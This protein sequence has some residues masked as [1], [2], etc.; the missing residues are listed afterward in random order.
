MANFTSRGDLIKQLTEKRFVQLF[1]D[2]GDG[3][4]EGTDVEGLNE[5][6][7]EAN[8]ITT[9][10]LYLHGFTREELNGLSRDRGIRRSATQIAA[11]LAG[12]RR[13]EF[14]NP[15]TGEGPFH[16]TGQRGRDYLKSVSVG[17]FR[18]R[19]EEQHGKNPATGGQNSIPDPP[20]VFSRDPNTGQTPGGF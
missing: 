13:T 1:D 8:D 19:L 15:A 4:V 18:S 14:I 9:S 17:E 12:V 16:L 5:V 20:F 7:F 11:Q 10:Q 3:A 6:L 2:D